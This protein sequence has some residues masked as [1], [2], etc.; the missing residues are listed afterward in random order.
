MLDITLGNRKS[1]I[2]TEDH[3]RVDLDF[4]KEVMS[5]DRSCME[6]T[7]RE[8]VKGLGNNTRS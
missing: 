8:M 5:V 4:H 6:E 2:L 1:T 3:T 7:G